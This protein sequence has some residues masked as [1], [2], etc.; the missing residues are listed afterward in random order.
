[1]Y[2]DQE[3]MKNFGRD[4]RLQEI[5]TEIQENPIVSNRAS[6]QSGSHRSKRIGKG[7]R[8]VKK[9]AKL[10]KRDELKHASDERKPKSADC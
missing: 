1:M 10:S 2:C 6:V 4:E 5:V 9:V 7:T 8:P 3:N